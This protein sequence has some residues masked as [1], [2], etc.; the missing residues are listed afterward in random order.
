LNK[1][2]FNKEK[3]INYWVESANEDY[4]TML[5]MYDSKRLSWTLFVGH[6]VIEKLLKAY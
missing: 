4:E 5:A 3:I 1:P 2:S 6:L